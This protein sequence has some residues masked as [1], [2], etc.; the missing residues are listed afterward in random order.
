M[1]IATSTKV[2]RYCEFCGRLYQVHLSR[3]SKGQG[4]HCS[5]KCANSNPCNRK[6]GEDNNLWRGGK[7]LAT[8]RHCNDQF[9]IS[10]YRKDTAK[11]CSRK[12]QGRALY[13]TLSVNENGYKNLKVNGKQILEHRLIASTL[14]GRRLL[15]KEIVHHRDRNKKNNSPENLMVFPS[16]SSHQKYHLTGELPD[17]VIYLGGSD[18]LA[19]GNS[20]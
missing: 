4:K 1:N 19:S 8:C 20:E 14:L 16:S 5:I 18:H 2:W 7:I 9:E 11:Y 3:L 15:D 17:D 13:E 12:C 10:P 6:S